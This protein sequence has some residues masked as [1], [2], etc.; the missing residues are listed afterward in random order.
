MTLSLHARGNLPPPTFPTPSF[1]DPSRPT[2]PHRTR[3]SHT[4][5]RPPLYF[6]TRLQ[7]HS[8]ASP[9]EVRTLMPANFELSRRTIPHPSNPVAPFLASPR[10]CLAVSLL[11]LCFAG[12]P[13]AP[14]QGHLAAARASSSLS[15]PSSLSPSESLELAHFQDLHE[16][17]TFGPWAMGLQAMLFDRSTS[18]LLG[19]V[20]DASMVQA[21]LNAIIEL[22]WSRQ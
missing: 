18:Q 21:T 4:A 8:T 1:P 19:L 7:K 6:E 13:P 22:L 12:P 9:Y 2:R 3:H 15:S 10:R 14:G 20:L 16:D 17:H 5:P 11:C